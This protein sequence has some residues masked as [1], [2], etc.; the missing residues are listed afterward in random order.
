M[1]IPRNLFNVTFRN[2]ANHNYSAIKSYYNLN[3][4]HS[5]GNYYII[6]YNPTRINFF[7]NNG[8]T[9]SDV[10]ELS[11]LRQYFD[12][13][14]KNMKPLIQRVVMSSD[15][16][17]KVMVRDL[18]ITN[19]KLGQTLHRN[20]SVW[21]TNRYKSFV[22]TL[23]FPKTGETIGGKLI[24]NNLLPR[25]YYIPKYSAGPKS[26]I[27]TPYHIARNGKPHVHIRRNNHAYEIRQASSVQGKAGKV[28]QFLSPI[29]YHSAEAVNIPHTRS[30]VLSHLYIRP[31]IYD[32][33]FNRLGINLR[34]KKVINNPTHYVRRGHKSI[35]ANSFRGALLNHSETTLKNI[36]K[37]PNYGITNIKPTN[38]TFKNNG[39]TKKIPIHS[40]NSLREIYRTLGR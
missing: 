10:Y 1:N 12:I 16:F 40:F 5:E 36:N 22:Q 14:I 38:G 33:F 8:I 28:M 34:T 18:K 15:F 3:K 4:K 2:V 17:I 11:M 37:L 24:N 19:A 25:T 20:M 13:V 39:V 30:I 32:D 6:E 7:Y 9:V 35:L 27:K 21:P 23:F 31:E 26:F 29:G